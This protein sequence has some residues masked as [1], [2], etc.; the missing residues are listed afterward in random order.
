M[1]VPPWPVIVL[2][3][4]VVGFFDALVHAKDAW[5]MMPE[6]PV[7]SAIAAVLALLALWVGFSGYR[8]L[9]V[10]EGAVR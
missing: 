2:A 8:G 7:L 6:G 4:V 10:R 9:V 5:A 1:S 3:T